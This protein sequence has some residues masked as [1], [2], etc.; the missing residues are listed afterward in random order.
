MGYVTTKYK[1]I[2]KLEER[3]V[4]LEE[5]VRLFYHAIYDSDDNY[6]AQDR[7]CKIAKKKVDVGPAIWDTYGDLIKEEE[8][9]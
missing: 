6:P 1:K 9:E 7:A 3:I 4:E 5:L 2:A 8:E